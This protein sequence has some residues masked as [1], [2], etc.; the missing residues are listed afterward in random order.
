MTSDFPKITDKDQR[1]WGC[2]HRSICCLLSYY[3]YLNY[4]IL[5]HNMLGNELGG[6]LYTLECF[7]SCVVLYFKLNFNNYRYPSSLILKDSLRLQLTVKVEI[8]AFKKVGPFCKMEKK[9]NF[10]NMLICFRVENTPPI[11]NR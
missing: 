7:S 3:Y 9:D 1:L 6:G 8:E 10:D 5:S 4:T 11:T 2:D